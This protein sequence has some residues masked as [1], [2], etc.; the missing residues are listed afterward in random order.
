[1]DLQRKQRRWVRDAKYLANILTSSNFKT[2]SFLV[3]EIELKTSCL[4]CVSLKGFLT[5]S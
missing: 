2:F 1:M 5:V 4:L 3:L